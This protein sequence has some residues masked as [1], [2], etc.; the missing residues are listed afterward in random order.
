MLIQEHE[1][2]AAAER[3][4]RQAHRTPVQQS[5]SF[6]FRAGQT[7]VFKCEQF[8]RTGSFKYRGAF[9]KI[10]SLTPEQR[11]RGIVAF[12]AFASKNSCRT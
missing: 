6:D 3:L 8:Q 5:R 9:N 1:V 12:P 10:A 7:V 11:Q 4:Q 2:Y